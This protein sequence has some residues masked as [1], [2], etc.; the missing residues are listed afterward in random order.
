MSLET[1]WGGLQGEKWRRSSVWIGLLGE[2]R[3]NSPLLQG[4]SFRIEAYEGEATLRF[5]RH[6]L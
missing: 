1:F 3:K 4:G 2:R 6:C 5:C